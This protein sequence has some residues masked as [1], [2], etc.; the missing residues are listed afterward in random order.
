MGMKK[1]NRGAKFAEGAR[2][3]NFS[4]RQAMENGGY[5]PEGVVLRATKKDGRWLYQVQVAGTDRIATWGEEV[6]GAVEV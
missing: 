3:F 4:V 2:V 5:P 6:L 1:K